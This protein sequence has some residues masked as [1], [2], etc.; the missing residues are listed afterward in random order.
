M[1]GGWITGT[2]RRMAIRRTGGEKNSID[3]NI[4]TLMVSLSL[5]GS[6]YAPYYSAIPSRKNIEPYDYSNFTLSNEKFG[7]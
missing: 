6:P 1:R 3:K 5:G 7:R 4:W 2:P